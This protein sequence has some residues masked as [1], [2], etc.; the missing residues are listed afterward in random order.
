MFDSQFYF[1]KVEDVNDPNKDGRVRVRV[2]GVH[3]SNPQEAPTDT[4]PWAP[5]MLPTTSPSYKGIG[6]SATGL[7]KGS[8]VMV[9]FMDGDDDLQEPFVLGTVSTVTDSS[10]DNPFNSIGACDPQTNEINA[11]NTPESFEAGEITEELADSTADKDSPNYQK[12]PEIQRWLDPY[13]PNYESQYSLPTKILYGINWIE[14]SGKSDAI[15]NAYTAEG[16]FQQKDVFWSE[17][18]TGGR[19]SSYGLSGYS[20]HNKDQ[21]SKAAAIYLFEMKKRYGWSDE[22]LLV[23]C[24]NQ[25]EGAIVS[26]LKKSKSTGVDWMN[27]INSEG[28]S[29]WTKY[30]EYMKQWGREIKATSLPDA[31]KPTSKVAWMDVA[32][33]QVGTIESSSGS[34]PKIEQYHKTGGLISARDDIPWCASFV[35]YCLVQAGMKRSGNSS[36]GPAGALSFNSYGVVV[37]PRYGAI[38]LIKTG[39]STGFSNSGYHVGFVNKVNSDGTV[40]ILGGNQSDSVKLS[41][42]K[43][44]NV[45]R[46]CWPS[47]AD[48]TQA[49]LEEKV[50]PQAATPIDCKRENTGDKYP[51][52]HVTK[53]TS[54]HVFEVDDTPGDERINTIHT[55]GS[56]KEY[57]PNGTVES[58]TVADKKDSVLGSKYTSVQGESFENVSGQKQTTVGGSSTEKVSGSKVINAGG[59]V[60]IDSP[61]LK[62]SKQV[63]S[64]NVITPT[65][66]FGGKQWK[67]KAKYSNELKSFVI[68]IE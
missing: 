50:G 7:I 43:A 1:A 47:E 18:Q 38:A 2:F 21:S 19:F 39:S 68:A 54:G 67:L 34:N 61:T 41:N 5:T 12:R 52:N 22:R 42:F 56:S 17:F 14:A 59:S 24:Y 37:T 44:S 26:A 40:S 45:V 11:Y 8:L 48:T 3:S 15:R 28:R 55:S 60:L 64:P 31:T 65:L 30:T 51:N 9:V 16:P 29:Y 25:G 36:Y 23:I 10:A 62:V 32:L 63:E 20:R 66:T 49:E 35:N 58:K 46:Y 4:L 53:T 13:G 57:L 33:S 27:Y 6:R